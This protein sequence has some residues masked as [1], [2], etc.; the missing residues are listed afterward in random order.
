MN[1]EIRD[2][3]RKKK[4]ELYSWKKQLEKSL[5]DAPEGRLCRSNSNG[6]MQYYVRGRTQLA[7]EKAATLIT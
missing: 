1:D 3:L 7:L 5:S 4:Q 6:Y 2:M